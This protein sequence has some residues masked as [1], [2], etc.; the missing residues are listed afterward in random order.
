MHMKTTSVELE[1][2]SKKT[3]FLVDKA[4]ARRYTIGMLKDAILKNA[5][6]CGD[7]DGLPENE[8]AVVFTAR[9]ANGWK[10]TCY[11]AER[12]ELDDILCFGRVDGFESELGYFTVDELLENEVEIEV[13]A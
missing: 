8:K 9:H 12:V 10:W 6:A 7:T 13:S 5:P 2:N 4:K 11:E 1:T 3:K